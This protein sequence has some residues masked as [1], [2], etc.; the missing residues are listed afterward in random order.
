MR[1]GDVTVEVAEPLVE[2]LVLVV[3]HLDHAV[4]DTISIGVI[5]A[6]RMT[7]DLDGPAIQ[8]F[9]VEERNPTTAGRGR[10]GRTGEC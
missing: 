2:F 10:I 1:I 9:S 4:L 5:F 3:V 6:E 7:G 8:I